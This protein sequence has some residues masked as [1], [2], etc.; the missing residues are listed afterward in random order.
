MADYTRISL[1]SAIGGLAAVA[2][3]PETFGLSLLAGAALGAGTDLAF[4]NYDDT[5]STGNSSFSWFPESAAGDIVFIGIVG[6]VAI[7]GAYFIYKKS[8]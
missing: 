7:G 4:Q 3:A 2:L 6:A 1:A 8:Q 5:D